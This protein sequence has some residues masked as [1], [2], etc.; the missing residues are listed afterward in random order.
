MYHYVMPSLQEALE[1]SGEK[2]SFS[3]IKMSG[4]DLKGRLEEMMRKYLFVN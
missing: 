3:G 4:D 2:T 1:K